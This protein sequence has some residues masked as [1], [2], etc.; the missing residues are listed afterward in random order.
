MTIIFFLNE[1]KALLSFVMANEVFL[2]FLFLVYF[3]G[4][5]FVLLS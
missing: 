4:I 3:C 2:S 1:Q 5:L